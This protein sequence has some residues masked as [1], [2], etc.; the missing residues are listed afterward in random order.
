MIKVLHYYP[1]EDAITA[2]CITL[3]TETMSQRVESEIADSTIVFKKKCKTWHPDIVHIYGDLQCSTTCRRVVSPC[4]MPF[5]SRQPY[6]VVI[7]R[8]PMES[9]RLQKEGAKR[10]EII[11]NPLFTKTT[12]FNEMDDKMTYVYQK[13]MDSNPLPL[14]DEVTKQA[15]PLLLK[16][17]LVG[18]KRWLAGETINID[19]I[20]FRTLFIYSELEGVLHLINKGLQLLDIE[21]PPY[22]KAACYLPDDFQVPTTS[23]ESSI[24]TQVCDIRDNGITILK[25]CNIFELLYD[26]TLNEDELI[27]EL[28]TEDN[29]ILFK[30]I[31]ALEDEILHLDYGFMP[32]PPIENRLTRKL[33]KD[34]YNHLQL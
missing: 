24:T 26:T 8:S 7:A 5:N 14:M 23:H 25:L 21:A 16:V 31:L 15:F 19:D 3:L 30:S 9:D 2:R 13:V 4:G 34:I 32:C 10:L 12:D 20:N 17:A 6:Y 22:Q 11:R 28:E 1:K 18:D 33:R 29:L 27:K